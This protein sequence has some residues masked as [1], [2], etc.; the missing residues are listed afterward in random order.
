MSAFPLMIL[1]IVTGSACAEEQGSARNELRQSVELHLK[2][3]DSQMLSERVQAERS[4]LDLGPE[5]L[6]YLPP[7]ELTP[8]VSVREAVKR[9][10]VQLE[11][12]AARD[13]ALASLVRISGEMTLAAVLKEVTAQTRNRVELG[14]DVQK[15]ASQT[16]S[17]E[18]DNRP[19]WEC[20]DDICQRMKLVS[21]FDAQR[22][23]LVLG[24][25][26]PKTPVELAVQR[27][28]PYR[29]AIHAAEVRPIVGNETARLLRISGKVSLEPRLRPLFLHFAAGDLS[30]VT[31][32]G[33]KLQP[34]NPAARYEHP[35]GDAGREVPLQLDYVIPNGESQSAVNLRGR[36]SVQ[37]AAGT[38]RVVFD[39]TSQSAGTARRRGGV[40]V[41]L[42]EVA[43]EPPQGEEIQAQIKV[44]VSYDAGGPAFESHR[45]WMFHNVVYMENEAHRRF[46]FTDYDTLL[47]ANGAVGV[48]YRW[49]HLPSPATQYQFVYEAPTLI[50]DLPLD[51]HL[52]AVPLNVDAV[53]AK[54]RGTSK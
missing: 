13:S 53:T 12:R 26:S 50:L 35:V 19:F 10:R 38:E 48:D 15:L 18:Y 43:F 6:M 39:R 9:I 8:S 29:M 7:P 5:S 14:T 31:T 51:V 46:E 45:T 37:L 11:R 42:R 24:S 27:S 21:T 40:T 22:N 30:A 36:L 16:L 33:L 2:Q 34:W 20:L 41:R 17:V 54:P 52:D 3:L 49:E 25:R 4:L 23:V 1:V 32:D 44:T 28:G 47:Q